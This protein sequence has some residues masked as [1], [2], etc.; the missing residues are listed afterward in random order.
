MVIR[1]APTTQKPYRLVPAGLRPI[2]LE[3]DKGAPGGTGTSNPPSA[4]GS[5]TD[6]NPG[7]QGGAQGGG[8]GTGGGGTSQQPPAQS[9]A[10][11]QQNN[12]TTFTQAD[13]DAAKAKWQ[14]DHDAE[15]AEAERKAKE[16]ADIANGRAAE[17]AKER[18][19]TIKKLEA[20]IARMEKPLLAQIEADTKDW[21]ASIVGKKPKDGGYEALLDWYEGYKDVAT[22]Y[23]SSQTQQANQSH[24]NGF[25]RTPDQQPPNNQRPVEG[26]LRNKYGPKQ[27]AS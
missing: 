12:P 27:K 17:V 9:G 24:G 6:A 15:V 19:D 2:L 22:E 14:A 13:M 4:G 11:G 7:G 1:T 26:I 21:P 5:G 8:T 16:D 18:L 3:G 25:Q 23:I 10:Q 20:S